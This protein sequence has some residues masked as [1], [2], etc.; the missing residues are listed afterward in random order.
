MKYCIIFLVVSIIIAIGLL[1]LLGFLLYSW[2]NTLF[3]S[4]MIPILVVVISSA[5]SIIIQFIESWMLKIIN[6]E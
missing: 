1:I 6:K 3:W 4:I 5:I 2:G